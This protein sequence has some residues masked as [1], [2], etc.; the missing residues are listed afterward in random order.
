MNVDAIFPSRFV[1]GE[2]IAG[3]KPTVT[4]S[5]LT[6]E[7]MGK[8]KEVNPVLWFSG[9]V[10]KGLVLNKTNTTTIASLYGKETDDW[11]GKKITLYT[12]EERHFGEMHQV[13]KVAKSVPVEAAPPKQAETVAANGQHVVSAPS[14]AAKL[15]TRNLRQWENE[16]YRD[17]LK[18]IVELSTRHDSLFEESTD[19]T[20]LVMLMREWDSDGEEEMPVVPAPGKSQSM[21]SYL[22]EKID[23][24][25]EMGSMGEPVL[26]YLTGRVITGGTPPNIK[27]KPLL[28]DLMKESKWDDA[29]I[30]CAFIINEQ[31]DR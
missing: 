30:A 8:D 24:A 14:A 31:V 17:Y 26:T 25:C 7:E 27:C 22:L 9:G 28:D 19:L 6:M 20:E 15:E 13:I 21:Y 3:K 10:K 11:K 1:K 2:D 29:I 23:E 4:I 5:H 16:S 18:K 12:Q